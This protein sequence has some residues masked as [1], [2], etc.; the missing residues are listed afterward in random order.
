VTAATTTT[1]HRPITRR[2]D[3]FGGRAHG[4]EL[5]GVKCAAVTKL[6]GDGLPKPNLIASNGKAVAEY[7]R[8]N[9]DML[10]AL[11]PQE[12]YDLAAG[13]PQRRREAA[14]NRGKTLHQLFD[15][16]AKGVDIDASEELLGPVTQLLRFM[17]D[18]QVK[19]IASE[20]TVVCRD[21][22][23]MG[24][25]DLM[26]TVGP[27]QQLALI[28]YKTGASGLWPEVAL[29]L[30]AYAWCDSY[31]IDASSP[32]F[33]EE[34]PMPLAPGQPPTRDSADD[35]LRFDLVAALWLQDDGYELCPVDAGPDTWRTFLYV[36]QVAQWVQ[37][38]VLTQDNRAELIAP[39]IAPPVV[40]G[41]R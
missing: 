17:D 26:A 34:L 32:G 28:D 6:I 4:Y 14:Q 36:A 11:G 8:D 30:A 31:I 35:Q 21:W 18:W 9:I 29:Q 25:A 37:K 27:R 40:R 33:H 7:V 16:L 20:V 5:D 3:Y 22:R 12:L 39:P 1:E 2:I 38:F 41:V 19:P 10:A 23:F 24:T 15:D 13:E